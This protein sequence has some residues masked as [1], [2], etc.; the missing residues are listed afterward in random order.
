MVD[1][2]LRDAQTFLRDARRDIFAVSSVEHA[3]SPEAFAS[4]VQTEGWEA[5]NIAPKIGN[6]A[7]VIESLGGLALYGDPAFALRELIQN[8]S[9]AIRA[10]RA[11]STLDPTEGRIE[12]VLSQKEGSLWLDVTDSGVGMSRH[13]LTNVLLDF[14]ASLWESDLVLTELPGL[15][16]NSFRAVGRFGIGFF[17][18]FMLGKHVKVSTR[19]FKRS[20][21]DDH[22]QWVLEFD[23][24]LKG[25][26]TLRRPEL[27]EELRRPGTRVS[28]EVTPDMLQEILSLDAL[29]DEIDS[30]FSN[31]FP[32]TPHESG[33]LA[34]QVQSQLSALVG[35]T[36]PSLDVA[37]SVSVFGEH[38]TMVV[39]AG[40]WETLSAESLMR[41]LYPRRSQNIGRL[42]ALRDASGR[43]VGRVGY[44]GKYG[45]RSVVTHGGLANG[46]VRGI[47]GLVCGH[48]NRDLARKVSAPL[49]TEATWERWAVEWLESEKCDLECRSAL[50]PLC[51][52]RD[53]ALYSFED[54]CLTERELMQRLAS[55]TEIIV[56]DGP[57]V[58][59]EYDD[60]SEQRFENL[61]TLDSAVIFLP[62]ARDDLCRDLELPRINYIKRLETLL[63]EAWNDFNQADDDNYPVADVD[64]VEILRPVTIYSKAL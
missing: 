16:H 26:P 1:R 44:R 21:D 33:L 57:P 7:R 54:N 25:N 51:P 11:L 52:T 32:E 13:I 14:G 27:S 60:V 53:L 35:A 55:L 39:S 47:V 50:H 30:L 58:H 10:S 12:I 36:C 18:V 29:Y 15:S 62:Y 63:R 19:R 42:L 37:V 2:E 31:A 64:G 45:D 17:A 40:D 34:A 59:E 41:R 20:P 23:A 56:S 61:L 43:C 4:N 22:E 3:H 46:H 49:A 38:P 28:I 5:V 6:V 48:N 24:G 9:D 8:G